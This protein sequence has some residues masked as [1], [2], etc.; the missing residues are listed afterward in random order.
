MMHDPTDGN[1]HDEAAGDRPAD[2]APGVDPGGASS[3]QAAPDPLVVEL[4]EARKRAS[5]LEARL[6]QV[7]KAYT[8]LEADN[9]AYRLR[10]SSDNEQKVQRKAGELVELFFEPVQN[11]KRSL[12]AENADTVALRQGLSITLEQFA[13]ALERLGLEEIT[14]IGAV[15]D[16]KVHDAIAI[17]PVGDPAQ[18]GRVVMVHATGYRIG[19]KILQPAQVV[20][21]KHG[22]G[23]EA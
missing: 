13:R 15:F 9:A 19:S 1:G 16:P 12:A 6:R 22:G 14:A 20:I 18:D 17:A 3:A 21:G 10:V 23:S 4:E 7:S 2:N 11:L 5:A 8:D